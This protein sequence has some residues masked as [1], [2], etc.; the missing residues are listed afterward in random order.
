MHQKRI[1][2][3]RSRWIQHAIGDAASIMAATQIEPITVP[4]AV[5]IRAGVA[6]VFSYAGEDNELQSNP[7]GTHFPLLGHRTANQRDGRSWDAAISPR[8]RY[9]LSRNKGG[10]APIASRQG[11]PVRPAEVTGTQS[12]KG[13]RGQ[14]F[15]WK[16]QVHTGKGLKMPFRRDQSTPGG[17]DNAT[18]SGTAILPARPR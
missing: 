13:P 6:V 11:P 1:A 3:V 14:T 9:S 8:V 2:K 15:L 4:G 7:S 18:S 10:I 17:S 5:R 12:R 16:E